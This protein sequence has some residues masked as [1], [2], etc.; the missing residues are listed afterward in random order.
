MAQVSGSRRRGRPSAGTEFDPA[1]LLRAALAA[2][3]ER[4]Y[5]GVS[6]RQVAREL[7]ISHALLNARCGTKRDLWFAAM[8]HVLTTLEQDLRA[9]AQAPD[10]DDLAALRDGIIA[11]VTFAA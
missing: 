5:D 8:N 10:T 9:A 4:G 6:V 11:H 3:A 1:V 2:F 7:G